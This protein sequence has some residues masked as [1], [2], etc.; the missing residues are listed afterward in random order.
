MPGDGPDTNR[1]VVVVVVV[2]V[3]WGVGVGGVKAHK[4]SPNL[5]STYLPGFVINTFQMLSYSNLTM[6][7]SYSFKNAW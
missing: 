1:Q 2:V 7:I 3:V 5:M 4:D 6:T